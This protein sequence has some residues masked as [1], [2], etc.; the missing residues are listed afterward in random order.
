MIIK[1]E[2]CWDLM[3]YCVLMHWG[4]HLLLY[5]ST[6]A[7]STRQRNDHYVYHNAAK[8]MVWLTV[9]SQLRDCGTCMDSFVI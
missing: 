4:I 1:M 5:D 2:K 6:N 3:H 9:V 7:Y 8:T